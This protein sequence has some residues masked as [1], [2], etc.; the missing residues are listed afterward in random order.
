MTGTEQLVE[1]AERALKFLANQVA[2]KPNGQHEDQ[3]CG[4][5]LV[6]ALMA[7]RNQSH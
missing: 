3:L 4:E 5:A 2:G 6:R 1:A 7:Y